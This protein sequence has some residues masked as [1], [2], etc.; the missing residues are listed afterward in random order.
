M[1]LSLFLGLW[2]GATARHGAAQTDFVN[3]ESPH[4]H[5]LELTPDG[6]LL[7]AVNTAD[8]RLEVF[9]LES[10]LP[11]GCASIPVGL[12]P[13]SVRAR[14]ATEAWV[15]NRVSD[16]VSVVDLATGHVVAT[17]AT[18]DE[19]ADV[20]FAGEPE[21][22]WVS[23]EGTNVVLVFD[24]LT[25]EAAPRRLV[26][27]GEGPRALARSADGKTVY[28]ALFASGNRSTILGGGS[29]FNLNFPPNVASD[30]V[31]P[32][33][34]RNPPP[35]AAGKPGFAPAPASQNPPPPRVGLIVKQ[36]A[37]GAWRDDFQGDWTHLVNGPQAARS[38]RLPG[39]ELRDHDLAFID[40]R[41]MRVRYA[42]GLMN[43]LLAIAVNPHSGA[44][45][46]AGTDGTN[47]VRFEP[48]LTGRFLRVELARVSAAG[49]RLAVLDLNPH[50][51]YARARV[52]P[53]ERRRALGDP[54]ALA[55]SA[56]G[57]RGYVAGLGS[58]NVVGL[59][60]AGVRTDE[61]PITVGA[62]PTGLALDDARARLYVLCRFE[63]ALAVI[64]LALR[65]ELARVRFHDAT[66]AAI[67]AGRRQLFDT[68]ATSGLG[69][70]ACASC[71]IDARNDRLA[72]D[73]GDPSGAMV[74][75]D[76]NNL[77]AGNPLLL[78]DKA[79]RRGAFEPFHPMKGPMTTQTLQA[80]IGTEPLHWR[81]D[82]AG[83]EA[84][85]GAF[86]SLLGA[87]VAPDARA[88]QDLEDYLATIA[89]P[90][91][92]FRTLENGLPTGLALPGHVTTGRFAPAGRPLPPGDARRGLELFRTG[93]LDNGRVNCV[94][95]HTLPSGVGPDRT[96]VDGRYEPIP[97]GPSGERHHMLV[98]MDGSTNAV[99]KVPQLRNLYTKVGFDLSRGSSP[100]GFGFLHDGSVD[101]LARFLNEPQFSLTSDQD[102][103]D[104]VA[105]LLA[106]SG[107]DLP[108]GSATNAEE[109]PGPP[110][111]DTH[112]GVGRQLTLRRAPSGA[113]LELL[114]RMLRLA[115]AG[116][117]GLIVQGRRAGL[118]RGW[119]LLG[120]DTFQSDRAAE[121]AT[122]AELYA[123]LG[124]GAELTFTLV[125][126]GSERR[127]GLDRDRDGAFDRDELDNG[128]DP[129]DPARQPSADAPR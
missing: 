26:L 5:P 24:P 93:K 46:A 8:Q 84:F 80:I 9:T 44:V 52:S 111:Q 14:H 125:P 114:A 66:P 31:G 56:D 33:S 75:L 17:L 65:S 90:P 3:W 48:R 101:T 78:E 42:G 63:G 18:E 110:S 113:E 120:R 118:A 95:C 1:R 13:V 112:A 37:S 16:S 71:H 73:L 103:A 7:L 25:P 119:C 69:H 126:R 122:L 70:A 35:N 92:P 30:P 54:R 104:L 11:V 72:W 129:A 2:L 39:W 77:A 128:G 64:D 60:S 74:P 83:L 12:D 106:F 58:N 15:V 4:V 87:D 86:V 61:A 98:S 96:L 67:R 34:G 91:N 100:R 97:A 117:V 107:S 89:Y 62:G 108:T 32:Y 76:G 23:C 27:A 85:A 47:E 43:A 6:K 21:R 127:L 124:P 102:T 121:R 115:E 68:H 57:A 59:D 105:F 45:F 109:P 20:V 51:D 94:N 99:M 40:T 55:W 49:E 36:D 53:V 88:L 116:R 79:L 82:R 28:A 81:G 10:G 50:L 41:D 19:P 38:G 29:E 22:A 123:P